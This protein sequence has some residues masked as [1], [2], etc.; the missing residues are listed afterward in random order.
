M[1]LEN[2]AL[3]ERSQTKKATYHI[4]PFFEMG[5]WLISEWD[6]HSFRIGKYVKTERG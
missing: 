4:I 6:Y 2:I 3:S 1:N 5:Y